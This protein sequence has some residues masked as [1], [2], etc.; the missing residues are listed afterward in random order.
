MTRLLTIALLLTTSAWAAP[1]LR[2]D[3]EVV[4][5]PK[6]YRDGDVVEIT[7]VTAT[8]PRLEQGDTLV[9]KGRV[10]LDSKPLAHLGLYLTQTDGDGREETDPEQTMS[11]SEGL[12][13]FELK[14]TIKHQGSLHISLYDEKT[15]R[16]F[17]GVYFGTRDQME[18]IA[19]RKLDYYLED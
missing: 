3:V 17:G 7:D 18:E 14:I 6:L 2:S 15:R 9:V 8:S 19:G 12:R 10:R 16:P 13:D 11:I 5:G 1:P 4:L